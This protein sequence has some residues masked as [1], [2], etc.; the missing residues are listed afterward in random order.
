MAP[1]VH[2]VKE[3]AELAKNVVVSEIQSYQTKLKG[4]V[5]FASKGDIRVVTVSKKFCEDNLRNAK[6]APELTERLDKKGC[7]KALLIY[8]KNNFVKL[9]PFLQNSNK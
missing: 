5:D 7:V 3:V 1:T 9:V 8:Q 6:E 2:S 4:L